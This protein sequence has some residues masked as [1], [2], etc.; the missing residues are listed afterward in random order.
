SRLAHHLGAVYQTIPP[1]PDVV[2]GLGQVR[3]DIAPPIIADNN[4][5]VSHRKVTCLSDYPDT[6]LWSIR[7][8]APTADIVGINGHP[9]V[10]ALLSL[11]RRE[12]VE[13]DNDH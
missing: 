7:T 1:D 13:G 3:Q 11:C 5:D 6:G 8:G 4:L 12:N 2:L 9:L 10:A